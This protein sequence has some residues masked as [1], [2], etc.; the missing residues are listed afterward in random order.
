MR[1]QPVYEKSTY[2]IQN[3]EDGRKLEVRCALVDI[4]TGY[5]AV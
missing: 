4:S 1:K 3:D 5:H 2:K